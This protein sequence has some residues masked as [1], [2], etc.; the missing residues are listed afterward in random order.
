MSDQA[1]EIVR[2]SDPEELARVAAERVIV[3]AR[4]AITARGACRLALAGG[5]TPKRLYALLAAE[6]AAID[7]SRVELFWG[8]ERVV[9]KDDPASN[10]RMAQEALLAHV[11]VAPERVHR[12]ETE[13]GADAAA[14]HYREVLGA[15][16]LDVCLLGMGGDGHTASLFPDTPGLQE[17]AGVIVTTSPL[18]PPERVS[19]ALDVL[20][21][22]GEVMVLVAGADK[23]SRLAEAYRQWRAPATATL[24]VAMVRPARLAW[25]VDRAAGAELV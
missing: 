19:L 5:S 23:A 1:P 11:A 18:P 24:P 22:A 14:A 10:F 25:I 3:A 8:D 9:P 7:W 4:G 13:R 6:P 20:S 15:Q 16:P 2:C 21:A 17:S 12:I